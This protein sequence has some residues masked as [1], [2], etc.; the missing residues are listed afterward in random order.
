VAAPRRVER[1][2]DVICLHPY[3]ATQLQRF[4]EEL[5][6]LDMLK[7][8]LHKITRHTPI[9]CRALMAGGRWMP[10]TSSASLSSRSR[11]PCTQVKV[12]WLSAGK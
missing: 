3:T 7:W 2:A 12:R 11:L 1:I 10:Q 8:Q 5:K 9:N 6:M 4:K